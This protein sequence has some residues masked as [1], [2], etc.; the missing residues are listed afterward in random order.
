[1]HHLIICQCK[2]KKHRKNH[3]R[4]TIELN[5]EELHNIREIKTVLLHATTITKPNL[6]NTMLETLKDTNKL[7]HSRILD[8]FKLNNSNNMGMAI[9]IL[10]HNKHT[11]H[12]KRTLMPLRR[13]TLKLKVTLHSNNNS[14][15]FSSNNTHSN[16]NMHNNNNTC[17]NSNNSSNSNKMLTIINNNLLNT[18]EIYIDII[19]RTYYF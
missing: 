12:S 8:L 15:M 2:Y 6:N 11:L 1:M 17:N 4:T 16:S 10:L 13:S 14:S 19:G 3:F 18:D 7:I 9:K 5:K